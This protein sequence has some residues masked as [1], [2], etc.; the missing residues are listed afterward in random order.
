MRPLALFPVLLLLTAFGA[1]ARP[2]AADGTDGPGAEV[3]RGNLGRRLDALFAGPGKDRLDGAV[4]VAR[5]GQVLLRKGYGLADPEGRIPV[6]PDTVFCIGSNAKPFTAAAI[7]RLEQAGRLRVQAP[8]TDFFDPV[9]ADKRKITLHHLLTH[10]SG[11]GEYHDRPGEGGDFAIMTRDEAVR[12]I[13]AQNLR[14]GP[15][16]GSAYSNSGFTLLAVVIEKVSGRTYEQFLREQI[17]EPAGMADTGF[18]GEK[19]WD[20]RRLAH[21]AGPEKLGDNS[22]PS[23]PGVTWALKGGGGIVSTV[24][25]Q[26]RWHRA[27]CGDE[28]L[29][30]ASKEKAF[31]VHV[32]DGKK[33]GGTGYAWFVAPTPRKTFAL[34]H[35][36]ASDYGFRSVLFSYPQEDVC[37]VGMTCRGQ[38]SRLSL[39]TRAAAK[40]LFPE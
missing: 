3:I 24:G 2:R 18:Y 1:D 12:R 27:L 37:I 33:P 38:S 36:G 4:L 17:F 25:D 15:G 26:Y 29:S 8:L 40:L 11:L 28:L 13:L 19:R 22:P 35:S 34:R 14:F 32:T 6:R 20:A 16:T 9:P 39:G 7:L 10:S 30:K 31:K 21:G 5:G 23:W